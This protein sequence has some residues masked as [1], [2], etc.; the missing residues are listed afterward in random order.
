MIASTSIEGTARR[1]TE[2]L[3]TTVHPTKFFVGRQVS[4]SGH[5]FVPHGVEG[6]LE[7]STSPLSQVALTSS[8]TQL[9]ITKADISEL[10]S[11]N[12]S[13]KGDQQGLGSETKDTEP[14]NQ[15][16]KRL[17]QRR[18]HRLQQQQFGSSSGP[19]NFFDQPSTT[20][21][22]ISSLTR[23]SFHL[24][25]YMAS[26]SILNPFGPESPGSPDSPSVYSNSDLSDDDD[27]AMHP[28]HEFNIEDRPFS[29][30]RLRAALAKSTERLFT[31]GIC[32]EEMP[33]DSIARP[34][35]CGHTFCCECLREHVTT[36]LIEHRFPIL[37]PTCTASK[38]KGTGVAGGTCCDRMVINPPIIV[39]HYVIFRSLSGPCP[40]PRTQR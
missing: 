16:Q 35:P 3:R 19:S 14:Q 22:H 37:C 9:S 25:S 28:R 8:L 23:L 6:G 38:G 29:A 10:R 17:M 34:E 2:L 4:Y 11:R 20:P 21:R 27:N 36:R 7:A 26:T 1:L 31:C 32:L 18:R 30:L 33:E 15:R 13:L 40:R 5:V 24:S 39:S 12:G